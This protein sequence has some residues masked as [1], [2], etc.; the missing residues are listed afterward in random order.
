VVALIDKYSGVG[1]DVSDVGDTC[2]ESIDK[3]KT[4]SVTKEELEHHLTQAKKYVAWLRK[5]EKDRA[6]KGKRI[7]KFELSFNFLLEQITSYLHYVGSRYFVKGQDREDMFQDSSVL[8]LDIIEDY[9][10]ESKK[11]LCLLHKCA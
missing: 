7:K 3:S 4:N 11:S 5:H 10:F 2:D 1:N 9:S 6:K 8:L